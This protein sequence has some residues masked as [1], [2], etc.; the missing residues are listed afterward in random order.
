MAM[1]LHYFICMCNSHLHKMG[2][3]NKLLLGANTRV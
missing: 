2:A 3:G 1:Q